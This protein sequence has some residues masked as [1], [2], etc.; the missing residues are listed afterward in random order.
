MTL[1][2]PS[3]FAPCPTC[4]CVRAGGALGGALGCAQLSS[5]CLLGEGRVTCVGIWQRFVQNWAICFLCVRGLAGLLPGTHS[6]FLS[7]TACRYVSEVDA[8]D[9]PLRLAP[10]NRRTCLS[11]TC[12]PT[13]SGIEDP[14][15][16][17]G[18]WVLPQRQNADVQTT[19]IHVCTAQRGREFFTRL[20]ACSW[21]T[22]SAMAATSHGLP[23]CERRPGARQWRRPPLVTCLA[24]AATH[25]PIR[26]HGAALFG[27]RGITRC[28]SLGLPFGWSCS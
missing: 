1:T 2:D 13:S 4:S 7:V 9:V 28:A 17:S 25:P 3:P 21:S 26:G 24:P 27:V 19:Q 6:H 22:L 11:R 12:T 16:T 8:C 10:L 14:R 23:P 5:P 20:R 15:I 18:T